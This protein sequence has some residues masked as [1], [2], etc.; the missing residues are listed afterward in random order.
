MQILWTQSVDPSILALHSAKEGNFVLVRDAQH[1]L[2][3]LNLDGQWITRHNHPAPIQLSAMSD[4]GKTI[5]L[6]DRRKQVTV[7]DGDFLP[8]GQWMLNK[9]PTALAVSCMGEWVAVSDEL[10]KV[11]VFQ[12]T[13]KAQWETQSARQLI[14]LSF[15]PEKPALVG[16]A[17]FGLV[18]AFGAS[19]K[20][21]WRDGL[22]ANVGSLSCSG[23]GARILVAC[24]TEGLLAYDWEKGPQGRIEGT[25]PSQLVSQSWTG[26]IVLT[27]G[28]E[29]NVTLRNK[30]GE[31]WRELRLPSVP[32]LLAVDP[33]G[34][35]ATVAL[36]NGSVI[37]LSLP[38]LPMKPV[39]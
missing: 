15:V 18:C 24:F 27:A 9:R 5:A 28:L 7:L 38:A 35:A 19:G 37:R 32:A 2:H 36:V 26:D 31:P 34:D 8:I 29:D 23:D 16:A 20:A 33:L 30:A 3:R 1:H 13:G 25:S 39:S 4:D 11:A 6:V 22:F 21:L 12:R 10:A 17:E 14:Q